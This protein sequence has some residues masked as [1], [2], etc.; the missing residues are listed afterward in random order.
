LKLYAEV[1]REPESE[2]RLAYDLDSEVAYA[3]SDDTGALMVNVSYEL[4]I[5]EYD[6]AAERATEDEG[7]ASVASV[8]VTMGSL[9]ELDARDQKEPFSDEELHAFA[10]TSGRFALFPFVREAVFN[11]T[12]RLTLPPL[13]LPLLKATL[14]ADVA[15]SKSRDSQETS[16]D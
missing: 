16:A 13:T 14:P 2:V 1:L 7:R 10:D 15:W 8:R 9:Y 3:I 4:D 6:D 5:H 12:G 11:L